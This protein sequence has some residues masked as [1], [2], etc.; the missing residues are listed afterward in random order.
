MRT[1]IIV[2]RI[3]DGSRIVDLAELIDGQIVQMS[4]SLWV[5]DL[6]EILSASCGAYQRVFAPN[7]RVEAIRQLAS[8]RVDRENLQQLLNIA[9]P[10]N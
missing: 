10:G 2:D 1:V 7:A 8:Q 5:K 4:S 6:G 9:G 3:A